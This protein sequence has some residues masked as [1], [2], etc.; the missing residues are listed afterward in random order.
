MSKTLIVLLCRSWYYINLFK[1]LE[2][3][4]WWW[5]GDT[6][7]RDFW[8]VSI[9]IHTMEVIFL[10]FLLF[11]SLWFLMET[12]HQRHKSFFFHGLTQDVTQ[13][14]S[15]SVLFTPQLSVLLH[16]QSSASILNS[17]FSLALPYLAIVLKRVQSHSQVPHQ[18]WRGSHLCL[19]SIP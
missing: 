7:E 16:F 19:K 17:V 15:Q 14:L 6:Q 1:K 13:S 8:L 2:S 9:L 10:V 18:L 3:W 5:V 4:E 11:F 12:L